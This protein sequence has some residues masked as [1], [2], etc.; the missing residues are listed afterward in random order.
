MELGT[1]LNG[2]K[3]C[4]CNVPFS[5]RRAKI[6]PYEF[7]VSLIFCF[8]QD[9]GARTIASL[10][11]KT[12]KLTGK[13]VSRGTFWERL[14]T[15]RLFTLLLESTITLSRSRTVLWWGWHL[16]WCRPTR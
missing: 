8:T 9:R 15:K 10:R 5:D 14:A 3:Q 13:S 16:R 6:E 4:F 2:L 1:I 11:K 7:I 12:I